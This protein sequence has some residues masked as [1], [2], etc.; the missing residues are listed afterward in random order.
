VT[1]PA[2]PGRAI[3]AWRILLIAFVTIYCALATLVARGLI[4]GF[5]LGTVDC[6]VMAIAT[7]IATLAVL[8]MGAIIDLP[9]A[10]WQHWLPERRWRAGR[11]PTCGYDA[12]RALCPECGTPFARPPAYASNW[13]TLRRTAWVVLPSW[14]MGLAAGLVL[15][16]FDE[17]AFMSTVATM[18]RIDPELR[19]HSHERAWPAEFATM[20]WAAGRGFFGPPPFDSPK[21]AHLGA[22]AGVGAGAGTGI[23]FAAAAPFE[24]DAAG[25][26]P[27]TMFAG[28]VFA[29]V[30]SGYFAMNSGFSTK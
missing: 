22:G 27:R 7:L 9:E 16:H 23:R 11:C 21:T 28:V 12:N 15:V 14:A 29:D 30:G 20:T 1:T 5:G 18:R 2:V 17:R 19:E 3:A 6:F 10:L 26:A 24:F 25:V 13:H 4:G 8:P